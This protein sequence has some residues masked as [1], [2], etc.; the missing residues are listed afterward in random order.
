MMIATNFINE[1]KKCAKKMFCVRMCGSH[2]PVWWTLMEARA[3]AEG[4]VVWMI[5]VTGEWQSRRS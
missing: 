5:V 1:Q 2:L 3:A 4:A